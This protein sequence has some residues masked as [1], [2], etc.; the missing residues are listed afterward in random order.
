[1][2]VEVGLEEIVDLL[3]N[4]QVRAMLLA[5]ADNRKIEEAKELIESGAPVRGTD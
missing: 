5:M 4:R 1:M 3:A 2:N